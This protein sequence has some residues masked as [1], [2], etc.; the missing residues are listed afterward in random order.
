MTSHSPNYR[1]WTRVVTVLGVLLLLALPS[2]PGALGE[3]PSTCNDITAYVGGLSH[4]TTWSISIEGHAIANYTGSPV[5]VECNNPIII[6][7]TISYQFMPVAG[8][9]IEPHTS[10]YGNFTVPYTSNLYVNY[11][12]L[13]SLSPSPSSVVVQTGLGFAE[14]VTPTC[15]VNTCP[16]I[17]WTYTTFP[18]WEGRIVSSSGPG[19]GPVSWQANAS[20][21]GVATLT[22]TASANGVTVSATVSISFSGSPPSRCVTG[23]NGAKTCTYWVQ[24]DE[25]G[26]AMSAN[27]WFTASTWG[28]VLIGGPSNGPCASGCIV[29]STGAHVDFDGLVN[30]TYHYATDAVAGYTVSPASGA[31]ITFTVNG[32]NVDPNITYTPLSPGHY[33]VTVTETGL[34][35]SVPNVVPGWSI[36][37]GGTTASST[38]AT[39]VLTVT[40]GTYAYTVQAPPGYSAS[41]ASGTMTVAGANQVLAITFTA[42]GGGC[43]PNG[44]GCGG[45]VGGGSTINWLDIGLI[46]LLIAVVLILVFVGEEGKKKH[47]GKRLSEAA[48]AW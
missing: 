35:S 21:Y 30:G 13:L 44:V 16:A 38:Q 42:T 2:M 26:L 24:F 34:P 40:N 12:T 20:A 37:F 22:A 41:P 8:Y 3:S 14:T 29:L 15:S 43:Q 4:G 48:D 27:P 18:S 31:L 6:P 17:S 33:S 28:V 46:L 32:A 23:F 11:S 5:V 19:G 47:L 45:V 36:T 25:S 9:S 39:I 10:E 1:M 7:E